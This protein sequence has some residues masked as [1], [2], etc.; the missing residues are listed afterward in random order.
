LVDILSVYQKHTY[1]RVFSMKSNEAVEKPYFRT[2]P[3]QNPH[4]AIKELL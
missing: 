4:R 3:C 1:Q 2:L